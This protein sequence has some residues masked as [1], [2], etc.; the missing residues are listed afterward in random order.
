MTEIVSNYLRPKAPKNSQDYKSIE[1]FLRTQKIYE[2]ALIKVDPTYMT[3]YKYMVLFE[4]ATLGIYTFHCQNLV[5]TL[6]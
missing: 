3:S 5:N 4:L 2:E 6:G 1:D